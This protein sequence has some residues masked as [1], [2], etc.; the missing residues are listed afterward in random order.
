LADDYSYSL[1]IFPL[2][3]PHPALLL[4][5]HPACSI[6]LPFLKRR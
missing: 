3:P 5:D 1:L 4:G 6:F 2:F